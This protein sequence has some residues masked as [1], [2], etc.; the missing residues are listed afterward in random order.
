MDYL[1]EKNIEKKLEQSFSK[2]N[3]SINP[4]GDVYIDGKL[5]MTE[6]QTIKEIR[7]PLGKHI[8]E[9][10]NKELGKKKS[11]EISVEDESSK[12]YTINLYKKD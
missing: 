3:F 12:S 1:K 4:K 2:I 10:V 6:V 7:L 8:I 11:F 5:F 9:V